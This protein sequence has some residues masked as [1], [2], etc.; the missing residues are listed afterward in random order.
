MRGFAVI[1][2]TSAVELQMGR[3]AEAVSMDP[4]EFRMMNAWRNGDISATQVK[5]EAC[6]AV[7]CMQRAAELAGIE[8][9]QHLKTM[10][11]DRR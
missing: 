4:W 3:L 8:L 10:S 6:A 2:G 9:P 5:V 7:E 11:S 1:N